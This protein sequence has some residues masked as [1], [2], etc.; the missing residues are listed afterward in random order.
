MNEAE[1][2]IINRLDLVIKLLAL[3]TLSDVESIKNKILK[4][5]KIGLKPDE[6]IRII[7]STIEDVINTIIKENISSDRDI[8][9]HYFSD[10]E[11]GIREI[12]DEFKKL[13]QKISFGVVQGLWQK[14]MSLGIVEPIRSGSGYRMKKI[15]S[16]E[17]LGYTIPFI[18]ITNKEGLK[19]N[20]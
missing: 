6:I 7:N 20:E 1:G 15:I 12:L 14:W 17:D 2:A 8:L 3:D 18:N 5:S 10:G 13:N 16:L 4:L 19:E 9:V 11:H